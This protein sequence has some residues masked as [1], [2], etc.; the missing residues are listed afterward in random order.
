MY[1]YITSYLQIRF[2]KRINNHLK[3]SNV[4]QKI[5]KTETDK[6]EVPKTYCIPVNVK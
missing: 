6:Q 2:E 4:L 1:E 3:I 5:E